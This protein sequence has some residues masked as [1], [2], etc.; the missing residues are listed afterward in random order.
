MPSRSLLSLA[1][2]TT[3]WFA[4]APAHAHV[5][6]DAPKSRYWQT[7]T[8][9]AD[10]TKL[11]NGPCGA[12]GDARTADASLV[13]TYKPGEKVMVKWK[14]TVQHPG[15][16]EIS[17]DSDGQDFPMP[18]TAPSLTSGV[19]VLAAS[20][21]DK[22]STDYTYEVTLPNMECSKCTLQLVQVM[23][24]KAAPYAAE[25]LYFNCADIIIKAD[26]AGGAG[27]ATS[28][29]ATSGGVGN[30]GNAGA[31]QG[32]SGAGS[33][34]ANTAGVSGMGP[35][36]GTTGAAGMPMTGAGAGGAPVLGL[37]GMAG[38]NAAGTAGATS[39]GGAT[40]SGGAPATS[41]GTLSVSG[42]APTGTAGALVVSGGAGTAPPNTG[43]PEEPGAGCSLGRSPNPRAWGWVVAAAGALVFRAR[44]RRRRAR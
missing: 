22:S 12:K 18:G 19:S 9:Q 38:N 32:A 30:G 28:A 26:G 39:S 33:G 31:G 5:S 27:G 13:T 1:A 29:G 2:L 16:F 37:G 11:K 24:T 14:E 42:G 17:F 36:G 43:T 4:A 40:A 41:G 20:I 7:N 15:H 6:L 35:V 23:T 34:G 10:Q 8:M 3:A 44:R 25:D 21:A